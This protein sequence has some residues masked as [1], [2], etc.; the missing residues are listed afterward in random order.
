[1]NKNNLSLFMLVALVTGNMIG[2]GVFLLP[3]ALA[4]YGV[5]GL[6][7]W[8][9]AAFGALIL[10]LIFSEYAQHF[11]AVGG[12]Y[13]YC[14][15]AFG[16]F[17]G[18]QTAFN[19]WLALWVGNAAIAVAF[20][21]YLSVFFP[22]IVTSKILSLV[23]AIASVWVLTAVNLLGIGYAGF[24][25]S[26]MMI[27]KIMPLFLI[28]FWGLGYIHLD[29]LRTGVA[30]HAK[31]GFDTLSQAA[32]LT[33]WS[34][35]GVESATVPADNVKDPHK[36]IPRATIIGVF[37]TIS[38]YLL[39]ALVV[40]GTVSPEQ[41]MM[42]TAPYADSALNIFGPW[43]QK[44]VAFGAMAA[45]FGALNGCILLQ[46]QIPYAASKDGLFPKLFM[47]KSST[48]IPYTG[49]VLS[50]MLISILLCFQY[51]DSL[52]DQFTFII[53]LATFATLIPYLFSSIA[54]LM[55]F[56]GRLTIKRWLVGAL[57]FLFSLGA[58]IGSGAEIVFLGA[59]VFFGAL[60]IYFWIKYNEGKR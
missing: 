44:L 24:M 28:G 49:L 26:L 9:L 41:L 53:K 45:S 42:S 32:F 30:P 4:S 43:G 8:A 21:S 6:M 29:Y 59:V 60:P 47:K 52:V 40:F 27:F 18:F 39:S 58:V 38:A 33:L 7:G 10:A 15:E 14:R 48:G 12:P 36:A 22:I 1:M 35:I 37:L 57:G 55:Y 2:S 17:V 5:V 54:M 34:F 25:Q 20:V 13:A 56:R 11:V 3:S 46:G 50:S 31:V 19:W 16:D 23:I 51:T